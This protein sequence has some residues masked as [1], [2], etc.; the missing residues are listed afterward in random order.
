LDTG[1]LHTFKTEKGVFKFLGIDYIP[2]K[3]R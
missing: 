1:V 2:P 3:N